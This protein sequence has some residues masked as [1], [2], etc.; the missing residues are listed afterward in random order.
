MDPDPDADLN[1]DPQHWK[2]VGSGIR[3][4]DLSPD[5]MLGAVL[6]FSQLLEIPP[7]HPP[8]P[9]DPTE[10]AVGGGGP[11]SRTP[12]SQPG[13]QGEAFVQLQHRLECAITIFPWVK[14]SITTINEK[15][16]FQ[17]A[18]SLEIFSADDENMEN[19]MYSRGNGTVPGN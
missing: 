18:S 8:G 6:V 15:T 13:E 12:H 3:N 16:I 7:G 14:K 1:P 4:T 19:I 10:L 17:A 11:V 5:T 9:P 2:K